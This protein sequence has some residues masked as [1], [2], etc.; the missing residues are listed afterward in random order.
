MSKIKRFF[1]VFK[2]SL[3]HSHYYLHIVRAPLIS[4]LKYFL[5]FFVLVGIYQNLN[6]YFNFLP[7][8]KVETIRIIDEARKNF[9]YDLEV[10]YDDGELNSNVNPLYLSFPSNLERV[11]GLTYKN[12][13]FIAIDNSFDSNN[14][15]NLASNSAFAI[16]KTQIFL[17]NY[18]NNWSQQGLKLINLFDLFE[19]KN[20]NLNYQTIGQQSEQVKSYLLDLYEKLFY[21]IFLTWPFFLIISKLFL[22]LFE[23]LFV[24]FF[25][26][27]FDLDLS[28]KKVWQ[29]SLHVFTIS[30]LITLIGQKIYDFDLGFLFSLSYWLIIF[31]LFFMFRKNKKRKKM[32]QSNSK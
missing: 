16:G 21:L 23:S 18:E 6:L 19:I 22:S 15:A 27:I 5:V 26:R 7:K 3:M 32:L 4:S 17:K 8:L 14:V 2:N 10:T 1:Y 28:Y 9:P 13:Q 12:D 25:F 30:Q 31:Y 11:Q 24:F 20:F 29:I